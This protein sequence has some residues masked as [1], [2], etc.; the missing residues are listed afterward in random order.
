MEITIFSPSL[1]EQ[2]ALIISN[3]WPLTSDWSLILRIWVFWTCCPHFMSLSSL[4]AL[5][6]SQRHLVA[7]PWRGLQ[8]AGAKWEEVGSRLGSRLLLGSRLTTGFWGY[9][10]PLNKTLP[11]TSTRKFWKLDPQKCELHYI[12]QKFIKYLRK[13]MQKGFIFFCEHYDLW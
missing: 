8:A 3:Y 7:R 1:T 13:C 12:K 9:G 11:G 6:L 5:T 4:L 2:F 10:I